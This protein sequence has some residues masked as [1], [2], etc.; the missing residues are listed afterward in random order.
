[1]DIQK[2]KTTR[3]QH[4]GYGDQEEHFYVQDE[5]QINKYA[6]QD[7]IA[8]AQNQYVDAQEVSQTDGIPIAHHDDKNMDIFIK[9]YSH[10]EGITENHTET[11]MR[12][13]IPMLTRQVTL[14]I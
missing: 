1:M 7:H 3:K 11:I 13:T 14:P 5:S 8:N 4:T 9:I 2:P 12:K 10:Q 6:V